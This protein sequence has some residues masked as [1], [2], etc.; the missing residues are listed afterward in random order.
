MKVNFSQVIK[1]FDGEPVQDLWKAE[2]REEPTLDERRA[3]VPGK[4]IK[5]AV[6]RDATL[7]IIANKA[8]VLG[9]ADRAADNEETKTRCYD[10][11]VRVYKGGEIDL[12]V[13]DIK[14]IKD[15]IVTAFFA[16]I[17]GPCVEMLDPRPIGVADK[18]AGAK[19]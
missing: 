10:L 12:S 9:A 4:L 8:L 19:V 16:S 1:D 18:K 17:V 13:D 7:G 5:A 6:L 15:R 3:G 2:Q 14:F 11:A